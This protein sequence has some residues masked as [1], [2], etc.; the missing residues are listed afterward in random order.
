MRKDRVLARPKRPKHGPLFTSKW[1]YSQGRWVLK[2]NEDG[3][4]EFD[5]VMAAY[6]GNPLYVLSLVDRGLMERAGKHRDQE[7]MKHAAGLGLLSAVRCWRPDG[8]GKL[9][10]LMAFHVRVAVRNE[11]DGRDYRS[12]GRNMLSLDEMTGEDGDSSL[13][14][15]MGVSTDDTANDT[16]ERWEALQEHLKK[17]NPRYRYIL[18]ERFAKGRTMES[19]AQELGVVRERIRQISLKAVAA[20]RCYAGLG[21][22]DEVNGRV[23]KLNRCEDPAIDLAKNLRRQRIELLTEAIRKQPGQ[24]VAELAYSTGLPEIFIHNVV[25]RGLAADPPKFRAEGESGKFS[26]NPRRWFVI[27]QV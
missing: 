17:L 16:R 21:S 14:E 13:L 5:R 12:R 20:V 25:K 22:K 15:F 6:H 7:A 1:L 4:R 11:L 8:G 26:K 2:M 3:R 23:A 9:E 19:L 18:V 10:T 27:E 24:T